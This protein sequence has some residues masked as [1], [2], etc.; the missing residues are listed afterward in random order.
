MVAREREGGRGGLGGG[1]DIAEGL[2]GTRS[3]A[4]PLP[5]TSARA[6]G[7]ASVTMAV[8]GAAAVAGAAGAAA[9]AVVSA[10]SLSLEDAGMPLMP[11]ELC[12]LLTAGSSLPT[13]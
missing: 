8:T 3:G 5:F 7:C 10:A 12:A 4:S 13:S 9:D 6:A 2:C 1:H 11:A